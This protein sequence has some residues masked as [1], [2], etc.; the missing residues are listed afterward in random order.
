MEIFV[1]PEFCCPLQA[2]TKKQY[3]WS[4]LKLR[5]IDN[6]VDNNFLNSKGYAG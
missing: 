5:E 4:L 3:D 1:L 6:H 2:E